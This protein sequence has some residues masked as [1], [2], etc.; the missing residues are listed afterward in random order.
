MTVVSMSLDQVA[1]SRARARANQC[2]SSPAYQ[3]A[4]NCPRQTSDECSFGSAVVRPTVVV[5]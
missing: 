5:S 4:S 2:T 1:S 3:R